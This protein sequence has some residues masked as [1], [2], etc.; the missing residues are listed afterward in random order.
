MPLFMIVSAYL[1]RYNYYYP[2]FLNLNAQES[3]ISSQ[4]LAAVFALIRTS[5]DILNSILQ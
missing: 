1:S 5:C 4:F 3:G 2:W